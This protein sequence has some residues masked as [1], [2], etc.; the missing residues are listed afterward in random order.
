MFYFVHVVLN[1]HLPKLLHDTPPPYPATHYQGFLLQA[2][3][4]RH[5]YPPTQMAYDALTKAGKP[6]D[7]LI[8]APLACISEDPLFRVADAWTLP[9]FQEQLA[10]QPI[11]L[12]QCNSVESTLCAHGNRRAT[13]DVIFECGEITS[14]QVWYSNEICARVMCL[15]LC[16][17][18]GQRLLCCVPRRC[19]VSGGSCGTTAGCESQINLIESSPV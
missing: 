10:G 13:W 16:R 19:F 8:A 12:P 15:L 4:R 5:K 7:K 9:S 2:L 3:L 11:P 1:I 18:A 6:W 17:V 14:R